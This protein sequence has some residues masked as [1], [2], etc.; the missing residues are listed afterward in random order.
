MDREDYMTTK[1]VA[2]KLGISRQRV[3]QL[4]KGGLLPAVKIG[5]WL[6]L[7]KDVESYPRSHRMNLKRGTREPKIS[8]NDLPY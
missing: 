4:R 3:A 1:E 6:F 2:V 7:R 8:A 5:V